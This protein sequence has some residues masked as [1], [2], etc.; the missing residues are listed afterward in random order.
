MQTVLPIRRLAVLLV[1]ALLGVGCLPAPP[2]L[3]PSH[4]GLIRPPVAPIVALDPNLRVVPGPVPFPFEANVG[5]VSAGVE[6]VLRA[7]DLQAGFGVGSVSYR[8]VGR[9]PAEAPTDVAAACEPRPRR[10]PTSEE[11]CRPLQAYQVRLELVG[12]QP[13]APVGTVPVATAIT[14]LVG[15][16]EQHH[17]GV[18][19]FL[20]VAYRDAWPGVDMLYERSERGLKSSYLVAHGAD[21]GAIRLAWH[22]ASD[23]HVDE[24]GVLVIRTPLGEL[25]ESAPVAWQERRDDGSRE[26][27]AARWATGE[28]GLDGGPTWGFSLGAYDPSRPLIVDPDLTYGTYLGGGGGEFSSGIAVDSAG[29]AYVVGA[30]SSSFFDFDGAPGFDQSFNGGDRFGIDDTFVVKLSPDGRSLSY[31]TF[32]GGVG[33][34]YG[35][36]IAVDGAGAAY[37]VGETSSVSFGFGGAPGF[38]QSYN[39]GDEDAFAVKLA[40]NGRSLTYGTYLGGGLPDVA[41]GITVDGIGAAYIVGYSSSD[42]FGFGGAP[43][44]D[45]SLNGTIDA[46]VVK[47]ASDGRGLT[48]GTFLGGERHEFG[49]GIAVDGTG[50]AYV[51]GDTYSSSF[52]FG[53][54]PGFDQSFGGGQGDGFVVKLAPDGRGLSYGTYLGSGLPD[55]ALGIAVDGVGAAYV[56]GATYSTDFAF[57]GAPGFDQVFDGGG[58]NAF[59]VKLKPD[60]RGLAYGTFLGGRDLDEGLAI[61]L[62]STGAAYVVGG[63]TSNAFRFGRSLIHD[64]AFSGDWDTFVV[65]LTPDGL[66]VADGAYLGGSGREFGFGIALDGA[67]AVYVAGQTLSGSFGF[68]GAPGFDQSFDGATDSFVVKLTTVACEQRPPVDVRTSRTGDGRL[69]VAIQANTSRTLTSNHL[70]GLNFTQLANATAEIAGRQLAAP[71]RVSL[72]DRPQSVTFFVR[73]VA[74]GQATSVQFEVLDRCPAPWKTL[75]GGGVSAF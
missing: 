1:A 49:Q 65:K 47:L 17:H 29:A 71:G 8:L 53:G 11:P 57:G 46:F 58:S 39:G 21:P 12:A 26:P 41:N 27:V 56:V 43:G 69:Q 15:P 25:R 52:G 59:V 75:V 54:A 19:A 38:D 16:T 5:Q 35:F 48:Y 61:A 64:S 37:V 22:G 3:D 44:F 4:P 7:G 9:D 40:P 14:Y 36:G 63:T 20:Q 67:G 74:T 72:P 10:R 68:G 62:D 60:G 18:P 50:A 66:N 73:R 51:V 13:V 23:A 34:D 2:T 30:T 33:H 55:I 45:H 28:P 31:G 42:T 70:Q 32:L 24:A 6:Y